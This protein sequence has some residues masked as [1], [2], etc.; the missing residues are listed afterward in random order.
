MRSQI[1]SAVRGAGVLS[2]KN[3]AI[4]ALPVLLLALSLHPSSSA[5]QPGDPDLT[6]HEWGTFTSV[7]GSNG[8]AVRWQPLTDATDLPNFV[9]HLNG[10]YFKL[11]LNGTVRME[12]P[13][14]YFYASR[15]TTVSVHVSFSKGLITEWYPHAAKAFPDPTTGDFT[16]YQ[17]HPNGSIAWNS[18]TI[19]PST[20]PVFPTENKPSRYYAARDTSAAP[21]RVSAPAYAQHEKFLFYR[22]VSSFAVPIS[23]KIAPDG[24]VQIDNLSSQEIPNL[25]LFE[26][27][28]RQA[29]Y[30]IAGPVQNET[31]L[32]LPALSDSADSVRS[33][34]EGIL[35][36]Q[37]LFPDE[38]HAMVE[39]WKDSWFEE[40]ARL[41]YI[42]PRAFVDS[43]LPLSITPAP[44]QLTRVF[45]GR[46]ELVTSA[47][48]NAVESAF[49][50]G[51]RATLAKYGRFLEPILETMIQESPNVARAAELRRY[52]NCV[53][54]GILLQAHN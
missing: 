21:L 8:L 19:E 45:V 11:G 49:A 16:L 23:A 32:S 33:D 43:V 3:R 22:G 25:I 18:V 6:A 35:I 1:T 51:D 53:Y 2:L 15:Q 28:G 42:V 34:L 30:R 38:A 54:N 4:F 31:N 37:G 48:Q 5:Q 46:I 24:S 40:G 29:G 20:S 52:L 47:T 10:A 50:S 44:A 12:T 7:A 39:T 13:V 14:L 41:I 9:E 36:A 27:R 17:K 26:R